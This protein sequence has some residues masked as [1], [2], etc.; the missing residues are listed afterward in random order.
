MKVKH[1]SIIFLSIFNGR[2]ISQNINEGL[3]DNR[4]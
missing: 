4:S 3:E 1:P 2:L